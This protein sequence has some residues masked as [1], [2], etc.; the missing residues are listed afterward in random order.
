MSYTQQQ[1]ANLFKKLIPSAT[2]NATSVTVN[3]NGVS[4]TFTKVTPKTQ[5]NNSS[6]SVF[7]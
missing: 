7:R 6:Q 4:V 5:V 1:L 3:L 2:E